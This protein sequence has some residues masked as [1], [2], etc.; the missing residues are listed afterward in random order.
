MTPTQLH[1]STIVRAVVIAAQNIAHLSSFLGFV[2]HF[3]A[4]SSFTLFIVQMAHSEG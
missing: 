1:E 2:H 4:L 3:L